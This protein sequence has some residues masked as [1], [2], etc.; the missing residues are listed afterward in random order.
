MRFFFLTKRNFSKQMKRLQYLNLCK[1]LNK[2]NIK[3]VFHSLNFRYIIFI[4]P[5]VQMTFANKK[6]NIKIYAY[7]YNLLILLFNIRPFFSPK[8]CSNH[9]DF[10]FLRYCNT[11]QFSFFFFKQLTTNSIFINSLMK[12]NVDK[13]VSNRYCYTSITQKFLFNHFC[14]NL[15]FLEFS[16][17]TFIKLIFIFKNYKKTILKK[18]ALF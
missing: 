14:F 13:S 15:Y 8:T 17:N 7:T 18:K 11:L 5:L 16:E 10:F 9:L 4:L 6:A 12:L 3:S 2:F 1:N